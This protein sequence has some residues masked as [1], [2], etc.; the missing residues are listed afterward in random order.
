MNI[1][2]NFLEHNI[3]DISKIYSMISILHKNVSDMI[4]KDSPIIDGEIKPYMRLLQDKQLPKN[5]QTATKSL[6]TLSKLF[7]RCVLWESPGT[8]INITPPANII[9]ATGA[10]Y[11]SLYNPNFC[12]DE[13]SGYL[14]TTELL[15][16]RYLNELVGNKNGW[17]I[18]TFG[19]KGTNLYAVKIGM[20]KSIPNSTLEGIQGQKAVIISSEKSHPC[21]AEVAD[22]IGIGK[23]SYIKI[24]VDNFGI[25][26]LKYL[27]KTAIKTIKDGTKIACIIANGGTTNEVT[28]DP[29]KKIIELRDKLV[30]QFKLDYIPHVHVDSVIGWS[31]LFFKYYDFDK[32]PLHM[33]IVEKGK[34]KSMLKKIKQIYFADSFG[35][36]FHKTGFCPYASSIFM[37]KKRAD[38]TTLNNSTDKTDNSMI[39]GE[40]SPFEYSFELSR[41]S[42]GPVS[43]FLALET[44]GIQGFQELIYNIFS[45]GEYI[46]KLLSNS[47]EFDVINMETE[48]FASLFVALPPKSNMQYKDFL[49][50][51]KETE[52]LIKYNYQ[53]YLY[54]LKALENGHINFK[55]TFSKSFKPFGA[56]SPTGALKIYQMSPVVK[57]QS[58]HKI[59]MQLI[60]LK[61]EFDSNKN[62]LLDT[63]KSPIDFVYR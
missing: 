38:L 30:K 20:V 40:Y 4:I 63:R 42:S 17:G 25:I 7:E 46:R 37:V 18:F 29:I 44:F 24:P 8:M 43:A 28:V 45:N 61:K 58:L 36:D 47:K 16:I 5:K 33:T 22:W 15:V 35:V 12:Q 11:T 59:I 55:I 62:E 10:F 32:N 31:W 1:K 52:N 39:F 26:N 27:E 49:V 2:K 57:K 41:S 50:S 53:F 34:I 19:G 13:S 23:N 51:D 6:K 21:H 14:I 9:S 3:D 60:D 54:H 48:G 56:K